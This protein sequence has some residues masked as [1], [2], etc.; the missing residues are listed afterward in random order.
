MSAPDVVL[1]HTLPLL[2]ALCLVPLAPGFEFCLAKAYLLFQELYGHAGVEHKGRNFGPA[3]FLVELCGAELRAAD[4]QRHHINAACNFSKR[5]NVF[6]RL[7]GTWCA[8]GRPAAASKEPPAERQ[9]APP[10]RAAGRRR[11]ERDDAPY[12][13]TQ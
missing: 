3:P 10:P 11:A 12:P 4:H 9:G 8:D 5:F 2:G 1:T 13:I 7:G 6:D